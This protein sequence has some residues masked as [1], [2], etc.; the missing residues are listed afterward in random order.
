MVGKEWE[1]AIKAAKVNRV[2][3]RQYTLGAIALRADGCTVV[4]TNGSDSAPA[5]SAH[6]EI[7]C[8]KK[9]GLDSVL[10]VVRVRKDGS[11]AMAFP[12]E[13]CRAY[14]KNKRVR[15]VWYSTPE[16]FASYAP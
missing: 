6:A 13:T 3:K 10:I 14:I 11:L 8:L 16:G 2:D 9:A 7:R 5:P 15:K 4:G 1:K 12:C